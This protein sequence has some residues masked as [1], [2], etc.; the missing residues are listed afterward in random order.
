MSN[1]ELES[2]TAALID[3]RRVYG[4]GSANVVTSS[5]RAP[6]AQPVFTTGLSGAAI[7]VNVAA[8]GYDANVDSLTVTDVA[9]VSGLATASVPTSTDVRVTGNAGVAQEVIS[10]FGVRDPAGGRSRGRLY[11]QITATPLTEVPI[12]GPSITLTA[13]SQLEAAIAAASGPVTIYLP[14]G[15]YMPTSTALWTLTKNDIALVALNNQGPRF[16]RP[17][18]LHGDR[19]VLWGARFLDGN[20]IGSW[21]ADQPALISI[22]GADCIVHRVALVMAGRNQTCGFNV[23]KTARRALIQYFS[24]NGAAILA[25]PTKQQCGIRFRDTPFRLDHVVRRGHFFGPTVASAEDNSAIACGSANIGDDHIDT[26]I[27]IEDC[28]FTSWLADP[29]TISLKNSGVTV[30][31]CS[32]M[33]SKGFVVR[34]G[35]RNRME[36]CWLQ[37]SVGMRV[38]NNDH[39]IIG[40]YS[41]AVADAIGIYSGTIDSATWNSVGGSAGHVHPAATNV[42]CIGNFGRLNIGA[43]GDAVKATGTRVEAH[44][45]PADIQLLLQQELTTTSPTTG[46]P[47]TRPT[48]PLAS[49]AVGPLAPL[50]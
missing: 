26:Y 34:H 11:A 27:L 15:D 6:V 45:N 39:V 13:A 20:S 48:G 43:A 23:R 35:Q 25:S 31:R 16:M 36:S 18:L 29:E 42:T 14:D 10:E 4:V 33:G 38:Y 44:A 22:G 37:N 9:V 32:N 2:M 8:A 28:L 19:Q 21:S 5:A 49:S 41:V 1:A 17:V 7:Q 24:I 40:N 30:R 12:P 50:S 3:P 47:F 46:T